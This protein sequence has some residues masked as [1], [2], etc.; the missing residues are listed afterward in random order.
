MMFTHVSTLAVLVLSAAAA[1]LAPSNN[2]TIVQLV[3]ALP[4]LSTLLTAL[5]AANLTGVL[6][7]PGPFTIFAPTDEA[8]AALLPAR[9][10]S[11][12]E[13]CLIEPCDHGTPPVRHSPNIEELQA[14]LQY[15]VI[16][17]SVYSKN[18]RDRK[19]IETL[20]GE[21]VEVSLRSN[22]AFVD[23]SRVVKADFA[24]SNGVVH[25]IDKVLEPLG[26]N[27]LYF[28]YI[29]G[30]YN[31]GQVDAGPRMPSAIF[32]TQN[33]QYLQ[34]YIDAVLAFSW[35]TPYPWRK[36]ELGTCGAAS[37][38]YV[39]VV[40]V[41]V[42]CQK[43]EGPFPGRLSNGTINWAPTKLMQP[44][45]VDLCDCN[46]GSS[47]PSTDCTDVPDNPLAG[48]W[49]SLCGPKFNEPINIDCF[50]LG[51]FE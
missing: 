23:R 19:R 31:C 6:S 4:E 13:P 17:S 41:P 34:E 49:C 20:E 24:A 27:H 32:D 22:G 44:I 51:H 1:P 3:E 43:I 45:C 48:K 36:L 16:D 26:I 46:Y 37:R 39:D 40:P 25:T 35:D 15:H 8:F 33:A 21:S 30:D 2:L 5:K 9:L 10:N 12:I 11:L 47:D 29:T 38:E 42:P 18:L 7:G 28:R 50:Q 14:V